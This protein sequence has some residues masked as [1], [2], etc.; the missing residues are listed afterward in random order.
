MCRGWM[1]KDSGDTR[2]VMMIHARCLT[3][4]PSQVFLRDCIQ[5]MRGLPD[6]C[7]DLIVSDPPYL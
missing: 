2:L 3:S 6:G 7:V 4:P 5:G 1:P